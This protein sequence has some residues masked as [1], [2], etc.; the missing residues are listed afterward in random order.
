METLECEDPED[1]E[2]KLEATEDPDPEWEECE[3][4]EKLDDDVLRA[5]SILAL[6]SG[7]FP[8]KSTSTND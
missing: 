6:H 1:K 8:S 7:H 4:E 5:I 3:E 2:D